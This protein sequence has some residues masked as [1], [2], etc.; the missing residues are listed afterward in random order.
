MWRESPPGS[1][2]ETAC[3]PARA[4][5]KVCG[6]GASQMAVSCAYCPETR[7]MFVASPIAPMARCWRS[8]V[9]ITAYGFGGQPRTIPSIP[10]KDIS[11]AFGA[12]PSVP[13]VACWPARAK[14]KP[15][16]FGVSMAFNEM[17]A[18]LFRRLS[19]SA[20]PR[21]KPAH[22]I[23][24]D[25]WYSIPSQPPGIANFTIAQVCPVVRRGMLNIPSRIFA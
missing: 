16:G 2:L 23:R 22:D 17:I 8:A 14:T 6:S 20:I 21:S 10:F 1:R 3:W 19:P 18:L 24:Y 25:L 9:W 7:G 13:M 5:I 11:K 12:S 4:T 15:S